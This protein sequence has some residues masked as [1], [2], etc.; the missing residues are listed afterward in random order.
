MAGLFDEP[1]VSFVRVAVERGVDQFPDGLTYG[2]PERLHPLQIG[3]L[4]TVPLGKGNTPTPAWVIQTSENPPILPKGKETKQVLEK[5]RDA[6]IL[7][8]DLVELAQWISQYYFAPI[9]P[10]LAT[11]LPGPVRHGTG[12][13][14]R[15]LIDFAKK[16]TPDVN[17]TSKQ[18]GVLDSLATIPES[19][20]PIE[21]SALMKLANLGSR[22][23][24]DRLV[25]HG[26]LIAHHVTRVE[27]TWFRQSVDATIPDSLTDEQ[28]NIIENITTTIGEYASHLIFGVT[29]SG[30]TEIYIRLIER[31]IADGGTALV[32]VP[33]ISLTP[34]TA[35]RLMGRFPEKRI[36]ILHSA[37]TKSQRHQQWSIVADGSADIVIG[38]RSAVFA[39]IPK[40]QLR[41]VIVDE[42]HDHS[43]KQ[44]NSPRYHGRDVAIRRAWNSNCPIILGSATPSMESWWNATRRNVSTLHT[45]R[46]RAPGLRAPDI[47][48]VDMRFERQRDVIGN[49]VLSAKLEKGMNETI[50]QGGQ[51]LLL[52]NRR[53]FAPWI[54]CSNRTCGWILKCDHCDSS[55][56]YHRKKPLEEAGF[57]RCHHCGTEQRVPKNCPDCSK[58][59]ILL[60]AGTQRVEALL[61]ES[62]QIP[63]EQ[64]ARLDSDTMKKSS[65]LHAMLDKFGSGEIK[66]LLGTQMI[67]KGLDFPNV[68][69][70]G[71]IDAD[72]AIDLPDFRAAERTYQLVSQVCGRC[73]RG[74]HPAKAIIQTYSP[75]A[76]AIELASKGAYEQFATSELSF[77]QTSHVPPVTR[78]A[79]FV[80]RDTVFEKAAGRAES[81]AD[82]LRSIAVGG[83]EIS[84]AAAC[85]LPR[86]SDRFRFDVIVTAQTSKELQTFLAKVRQTISAS[87][88]LVVDIDPISML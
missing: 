66:I 81:L 35:A 36:A 64:I 28:D 34:Q 25:E 78:M 10:T 84:P 50:S 39:P 46:N 22:G 19:E 14:T 8:E 4:V 29:G 31:A 67:A 7:P 82:R 6:M 53:G 44:D 88:E 68:Q 76:A 2:V 27:A 80:V 51:V 56:V 32:L 33:E 23:P 72:T 83:I 21:A 79:R 74:E 70:V 48:V 87:R 60:G 20:R 52:L 63:N 45:L 75:D 59:V 16:P 17:I 85:V 11:M 5:D 47:E 54:A 38:A 1:N 15:Q 24:I 57:V 13:V 49:S 58:K 30:K 42:E 86:L 43:Y 62:L 69:L 12:L 40:D 71:V 73:G 18:Q 65:D 37:L 77:R 26:Q 61:R 41:I 9:G 55:M 3:Q